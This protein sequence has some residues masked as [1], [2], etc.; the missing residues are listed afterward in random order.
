MAVVTWPRLVSGCRP[1]RSVVPH[2]VCC[3]KAGTGGSRI[4]G[5]RAAQVCVVDNPFCLM[6]ACLTTRCWPMTGMD[7]MHASNAEF[8]L[9]LLQSRGCVTMANRA[10]SLSSCRLNACHHCLAAGL[11]QRLEQLTLQPQSIGLAQRSANGSSRESSPS[12]RA[13]SQFCHC[14][15]LCLTTRRLHTKSTCMVPKESRT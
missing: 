14:R 12:V 13:R 1:R 7:R 4:Q 6:H 2:S 9:Q 10:C 3:C 8:Q 11:C 15:E 5:A